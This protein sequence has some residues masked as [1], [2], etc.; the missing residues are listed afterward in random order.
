MPAETLLDRPPPRR[1]ASL[2]AVTVHATDGDI[3]ARLAD[4]PGIR[5]VEDT[6]DAA[7]TVTDLPRVEPEGPPT[8]VL[9]EGA[10]ALAALRAGARA[11]LPPDAAP[12]LLAAALP[13]IARGLAVL[14][15][16]QLASLA[17]RA[18]PPVAMEAGLTRRE[19]EVLDLLAA[20]ASNK[21]IARRLGLSFHTAKA[22]VAAVLQKLGAASRADAVARGARAGLVL[23]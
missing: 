1:P 9:A 8:L 4:L 20:G 15:P 16:A 11:V 13:A 23:L 6:A 5:L 2:A 21:V 14:P 12:A 17:G 18:A 7:V 3:A 10:T 19:R 22:H